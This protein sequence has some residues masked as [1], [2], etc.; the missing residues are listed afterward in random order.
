MGN[1]DVFGYLR[2]MANGDIYL[3]KRGSLEGILSMTRMM[4]CAYVV[5]ARITCVVN[6]IMHQKI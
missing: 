1:F 5:C 4:V 2:V 6:R 3:K